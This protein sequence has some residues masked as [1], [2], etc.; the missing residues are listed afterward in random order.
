MENQSPKAVYAVKFRKD[1]E[2]IVQREGGQRPSSVHADQRR[3]ES[4]AIKLARRNYPSKVVVYNQN[5]S[6]A[7]E[8]IIEPA[9]RAKPTKVAGG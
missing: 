2:W 8:D 1:G 9:K 4:A 3:A 6:V 7:R 5:G